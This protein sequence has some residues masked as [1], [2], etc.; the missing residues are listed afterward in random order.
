[1]IPP[2]VRSLLRQG[3]QSASRYRAALRRSR[4]LRQYS[5]IYERFSDYTMIGCGQFVT[6]LEL[7]TSIRH[8][9]GCVVECGV[10]RGGMAAGI[11][12]VLGPDRDYFLFDSFEGLPDAKPIDGTAALNWQKNT[13]A[14]GY[15]DNCTAD[16]SFAREA[17]TKAGLPRA[18]LVKGWF[19]NTLPGF[20]PPSPIALLRL[21][22]DWYEST[23]TCL[24]NLFPHVINDGLI[25]IDDYYTWDGCSRAVHDYLSRHSRCERIASQD[26]VCLMRKRSEESTPVK[27]V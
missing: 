23:I 25:L 1:M 21:D 18:T 12:T 8:L 5:R 22:G 16:E 17:M 15:H 24:E 9:P 3:R 4:T 6:N 19:E 26:G 20:T 13:T 27:R 14:P 7:A 11:A 10:W 2:S